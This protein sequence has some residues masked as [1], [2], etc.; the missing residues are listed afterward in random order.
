MDKYDQLKEAMGDLEEDTVLEILREVM[1]Y[2][3]GEEESK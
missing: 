1:G 2:E 3:P